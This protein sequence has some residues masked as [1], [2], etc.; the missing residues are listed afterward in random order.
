MSLKEV[1]VD[2]AVSWESQ[3]GL[4]MALKTKGAR[5]QARWL[6]I[7]FLNTECNVMFTSSKKGNMGPLLNVN[8]CT[9]HVY[10]NVKSLLSI[11]STR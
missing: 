10:G 9:I 1:T 5:W 2:I 7:S 11:L 3:V 8:A 6:L 4:V